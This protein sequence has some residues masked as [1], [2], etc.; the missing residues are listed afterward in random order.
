MLEEN[1]KA[2]RSDEKGKKMLLQRES[3]FNRPGQDPYLVL[4]PEQEDGTTSWKP[5]D[6]SLVNW[7]A[8]HTVSS[9]RFAVLL[10]FALMACL[11][12]ADEQIEAAHTSRTDLV[13][14]NISMHCLYVLL[15]VLI[16]PRWVVATHNPNKSGVGQLFRR[17]RH[18][19]VA[20]AVLLI[21]CLL[22]GD[23]QVEDVNY[24]MSSFEEHN[25]HVFVCSYI[26]PSRSE[27]T[28]SLCDTYGIQAMHFGGRR[29]PELDILHL[30]YHLVYLTYVP[31]LFQ[32]R[33]LESLSKDKSKLILERRSGKIEQLSHS[34]PQRAAVAARRLKP[35]PS[36]EV[37]EH[38][39]ECRFSTS[40]QLYGK[41][42]E[43]RLVLVGDAGAR[44]NFDPREAFEENKTSSSLRFDPNS[45]GH[46]AGLTHFLIILVH[47]LDT[48]YEGWKETLNTL[49]SIVGFEVTID[50]ET[51]QSSL[52]E[53][54]HCLAYT[55]DVSVRT[56]Y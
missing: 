5:D 48:W 16:D 45:L 11:L 12:R 54:R 38:F 28:I 34:Q 40:L 53:R 20:E 22:Q 7:E 9:L 49:D 4:P 19:R 36:Y 13:S 21:E 18:M 32:A 55:E 37:P 33:K 35:Q 52:A 1:A 31:I 6:S 43:F 23:I 41:G 17:P 25:M 26:K 51:Q 44:V 2:F 50:H 8:Y 3:I 27:A 29:L 24:D 30:Q 10:R 39:E 46:L 56:F 42:G 14:W 15:H 47:L